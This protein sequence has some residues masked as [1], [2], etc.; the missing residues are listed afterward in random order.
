MHPVMRPALV[1]LLSS[2]ASVGLLWW[3]DQE[4]PPGHAPLEAAAASGGEYRLDELALLRE[5]MRYVRDGY[6]E[7]ARID[8]ERMFVAA[9]EAVER[10]VPEVMFRRDGDQVIARVGTWRS[11][12][13]VDPLRRTDEVVEQLAPIAALLRQ[14]LDAE[15]IPD[16]DAHLQPHAMIELAMAN[17]ILETLDPHS[18]LMPPEASREMDVENRGEFGGLGINIVMEDGQLVLEYPMPDTPAARAGLRD[19]DRIRRIDGV[20]TI[21]MTMDEAI[22]L[23]RGPVGAPV[24]LEIVRDGAAAPF[25]VTVYRANIQLAPVE[26]FPLGGGYGYARIR[27]F[28]STVAA[29]LRAELQALVREEGALKGLVLDLRDNP[30]GYLS[31]AIAVANLFLTDGEIVSTRGPRDPSPRVERADGEEPK[32]RYP[33]VVLANAGSASASEIVAGALRNNERAVIV[34]ERT[35]GKGSVQNL[36]DVMFDSK[37]KITVAQYFTPGE[38]SIQSVG[39]PADIEIIPTWVGT[40]ADGAV[41][42]WFSAALFSRDRLRREADLDEHLD[43]GQDADLEPAWSMRVLRPWERSERRAYEPPDP[44]TDPELRAALGVL[45]VAPNA[46]RPEM[47]EAAAKMVRHERVAEDERISAAF[48]AGGIDWTDGPDPVRPEVALELR[49]GPSGVLEAGARTMVELQVTNRG[50]EPL[51]RL[52]AVAEDHDLFEGAEFPFGFLAPGETRSFRVPVRVEEGYPSERAAVNISLR[53]SEGHE[54]AR[55]PLMVETVGRALPQLAWSWKVDEP[56]DGRIDVGD[57][58]KL[59]VEV[60]NVGKGATRAASVRIKNGSGKAADILL[61]TL[62]PGSLRDEAGQP[63]AVE[64]LRCQPVLQPGERWSGAFEVRVLEPLAAG[65]RLTLSL[66]DGAA[67][68]YASVVRGGFVGYYRQ[69][70]VVSF[71]LGPAS[72]WSA[73]RTPPRVDIT[74]APGL[75]T[76]SELVTVSGRVSDDVGIADVLVYVGDDKVFFQGS[77]AGSGIRSVPFSADVY[78]EPGRNTISVLARDEQ[79]FSWATSRVVW[80]SEAELQAAF[81]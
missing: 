65:Y 12:L 66:G 45:Q 46:R 61:G 71:A 8:P 74:L 53:G 41:D 68:D 33:L 19:G 37:L 9:L 58:V 14:H 18:V 35:F 49:V 31:Q 22:E 5:T 50:V 11:T 59:Q 43:G 48:Q 10:L 40:R 3:T 69:E 55:Q 72:A 54:I 75:E 20:P 27:A 47:L 57:V 80:R 1:F 30:G 62:E 28:H 7:P 67:F 17:G 81:K 77:D 39:I 78:I 32:A 29:D 79:G 64:G 15:D 21:N 73:R 34:G 16:P 42:P 56:V 24:L 2:L 63:C 70:E 44:R 25:D 36:H 51:H 60:E 52:V 23:L 26:A 4:G 13:L 6:V 76:T 38:R